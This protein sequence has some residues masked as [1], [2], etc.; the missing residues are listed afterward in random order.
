M[1]TFGALFDSPASTG[2]LLW[3]LLV[4]ASPAGATHFGRPKLAASVRLR[5][6]ADIF[7]PRIRLRLGMLPPG[8]PIF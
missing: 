6:P 7:C 3:T 2:A 4:R 5:R 1:D 8:R